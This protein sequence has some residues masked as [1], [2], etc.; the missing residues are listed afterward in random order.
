[1]RILGCDRALAAVDFDHVGAHVREQA[2]GEGA[3]EYVGKV[4]YLDTGQ[5]LVTRHISVLLRAG[6]LLPIHSRCNSLHGLCLRF[7]GPKLPGCLAEM[8]GRAG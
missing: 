8:V 6:L 2:R 7:I 4:E 5:R 1:M 3:G